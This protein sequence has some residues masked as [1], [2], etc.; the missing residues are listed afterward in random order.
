[1]IDSQRLQQII[2][3]M[4][5]TDQMKLVYRTVEI[6]TNQ[7]GESDAEHSWHLALFLMLL[8]KDLPKNIDILRLYKM[9]LIHDMVEIY[10]GDTPLY[11]TVGRLDKVEREAQA[12]EKLFG[13]LPTDLKEEFFALFNEFELLETLESK[14]AKAFD[15][16]HP[17]IQNLCSNGTDYKKFKA[18]YEDEKQRIEKY[19]NF[20]STLI[21]ISDFLLDEAKKCGYIY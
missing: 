6:S 1:M 19:V 15:K 16:I 12:A 9:L 5:V 11:D 13:Q 17:L 2:N 21:Q 7:R 3:F 20:D 10:A 18:T 14:I 4:R 8:E